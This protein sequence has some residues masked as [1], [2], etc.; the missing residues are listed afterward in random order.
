MMLN[1]LKFVENP[2]SNYALSSQDRFIYQHGLFNCRILK[3][4]VA[5]EVLKSVK[6]YDPQNKLSREQKE[7]IV[8]NSNKEVLCYICGKYEE[9]PDI[10][11]YGDDKIAFQ[12]DCFQ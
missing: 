1:D 10:F 6:E 3:F 4:K 11:V 8:K 9:R 5:N 2:K 12:I 7:F